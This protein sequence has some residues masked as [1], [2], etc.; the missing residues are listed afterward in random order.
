MDPLSLH[1]VDL[2]NNDFSGS[3]PEDWRLDQLAWLDLSNN[4]FEGA[5]G[6]NGRQ[7]RRSVCS[8]LP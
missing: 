6:Q 8:R 7:G 3:L 4:M 2:S 1:T 5:Q